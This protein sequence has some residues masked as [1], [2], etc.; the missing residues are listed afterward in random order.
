MTVIC[1]VHGKVKC[2]IGLV[3]DGEVCRNGLESTISGNV[4]GNIIVH[5]K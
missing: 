2:W 3:P 4:D 1:L 5:E